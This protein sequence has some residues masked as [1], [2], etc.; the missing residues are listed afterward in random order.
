MS[1]APATQ[2]ARS[3]DGTRLAYQVTG[4]GP[5]DLVFMPGMAVPVDLMWD[6]P[7]LIR[8]RNRLGGF[9]R[10]QV[11]ALSASIAMHST[12]RRPAAVAV[13]EANRGLVRASPW[14]I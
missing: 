14:R 5:L 11:D 10:T 9:S 2:Y 12:R 1:G 13:G 4:D 3:A 6:D 8:I 7:G